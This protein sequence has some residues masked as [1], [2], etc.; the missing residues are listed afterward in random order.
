M[1]L[2]FRKREL[3]IELKEKEISEVAEK[4]HSKIEKDRLGVKKIN[5]ILANGITL[6]VSQA[7]GH[8]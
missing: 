2:N 1:I 4:L 6:K 3:R 7:A 8:K 5:A